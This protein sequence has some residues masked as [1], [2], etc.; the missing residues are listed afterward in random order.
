M[1]RLSAEYYFI[2]GKW[3]LE[4]KAGDVDGSFTLLLRKIKG[5]WV[6][7]CDHSS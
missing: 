1:D 2:V 7:I 6:I 3:A 5:T 4:R